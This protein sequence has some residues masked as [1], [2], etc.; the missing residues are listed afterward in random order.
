MANKFSQAH[1]EIRFYLPLEGEAWKD[2][3]ETPAYQ[4]LLQ[5]GLLSVHQT[6]KGN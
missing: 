5:A 4:H 6:K 2:F 3:Q 1:A